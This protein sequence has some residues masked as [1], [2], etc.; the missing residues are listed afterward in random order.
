MKKF[1]KYLLY[2]I[3]V[4]FSISCNEILFQ[5]P[6]S[7]ISTANFWQ[8]EDD[9]KAGLRGMYA[10]L[11]EEAAQNFFLWGEARSELQVQSFFIA[12]G[13]IPIFENDLDPITSGPN[14]MGL[15]TSLHDAN[16]LLKYV[17]NI[18]FSSTDEKNDILAQAHA[19]RAFIYYLLVKT[20]GEVPLVIE[21]TE[22]FDPETTFKEKATINELFSFIKSEVD[23]AIELFPSNSYP[24]GRN[25][26][27]RPAVQVLKADVY[28]WTGKRLGGGNDD[29][30]IALTSLD[31]AENSEIS[32]LENY[33][34]IFSYENKGNEEIMMAMRFE[35]FEA[36]Q[37]IFSNM[38]ISG[39]IMPRNTDQETLEA[40]GAGGGFAYFEIQR[41][42]VNRFRSDDQR[43]K[44]SFIEIYEYN[45]DG[46]PEYYTSVQSK[47]KG[48]VVGGVRQFLDDFVIYRYA[49]LLLLR[50]EAKNALGMDPSEEMNQIRQRA[51]GDQFSQFQF[52]NSSQEENDEE[53][54]EERLFEFLLEGKYWWDLIRFNKV[55]EEV[56]SL[57]DNEDNLLFP[58][59][60]TTLSLNP[61]LSQNPGY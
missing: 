53:I 3:L 37:T 5:D 33:S 6:V 58:I 26:W 28:L 36:P 13:L 1:I 7:Q 22:S 41:N 57:Q 31:E 44:G 19:T 9:A 30:N 39:A 4:S 29:F 55:F 2:S 25:L 11:R 20:W 15:Y 46:L 47:Y 18:E 35:E 16:L 32:L 50:A 40:I 43:K 52:V 8:N 51:Y 56:P 59:P 54:L 10:R 17:P 38:Y 14:W 42:V 48:L 21:P 34:D 23:L 45:A 60:E 24:D 61:L 12:G 49:D 27:S